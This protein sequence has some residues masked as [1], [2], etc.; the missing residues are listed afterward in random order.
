MQSAVKKKKTV[1]SYRFI[2]LS[3]GIFQEGNDKKRTED[4]RITDE[5]SSFTASS[6]KKSSLTIDTFTG[7]QGKVSWTEGHDEPMEEDEP[8]DLEGTVGVP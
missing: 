6:C 4:M 2:D 1:P 7:F 3:T 8:E 5:G